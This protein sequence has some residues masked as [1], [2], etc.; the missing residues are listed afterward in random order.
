MNKSYNSILFLNR[1]H[2]LIVT[3][4]LS[5]S[6]CFFHTI[7]GVFIDSDINGGH[8]DGLDYTTRGYGDGKLFFVFN[9]VIVQD[10]DLDAAR[11]ATNGITR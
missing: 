11:R 8:V 2:N 6:H 7:R 9:N 1:L 5:I 4:Q 3:Q 10:I